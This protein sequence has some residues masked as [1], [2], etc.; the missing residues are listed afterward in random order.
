MLRSAAAPAGGVVADGSSGRLVMAED[1]DSPMADTFA[2]GRD[3]NT[4]AKQVNL[5]RSWEIPVTY[6]MS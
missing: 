2:A 1:V 6:L 5:E 4:A 3:W